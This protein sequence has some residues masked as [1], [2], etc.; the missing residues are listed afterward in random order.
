MLREV[1]IRSSGTG[2]DQSGSKGQPSP[3]RECRRHLLEENGR[4]FGQPQSPLLALGQGVLVSVTCSPRSNRQQQCSWI[5]LDIS[6]KIRPEGKR[7]QERKLRCAAFGQQ[8]NSK[9]GPM[10]ALHKIDT[11]RTLCI[12]GYCAELYCW[13]ILGP[14][15]DS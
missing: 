7:E 4:E 11:C 9:H 1:Q 8:D 12:I 14:A 3:P 6:R 5:R 10:A 13:C 15:T 2:K